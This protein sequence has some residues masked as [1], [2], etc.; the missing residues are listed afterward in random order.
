[1]TLRN[2]LVNLVQLMPE[3]LRYLLHES[4]TNRAL[5]KKPNGIDWAL[6]PRQTTFVDCLVRQTHPQ[7]QELT[8]GIKRTCVYGAGVGLVGD[9]DSTLAD[10]LALAW[11]MSGK[12]HTGQEVRVLGENYSLLEQKG[13]RT[14]KV[15]LKVVDL[16]GAFQGRVEQRPRRE[17]G[18]HRGNQSVHRTSTITDVNMN[19][20]VFI[21]RPFMFNIQSIIKIAVEQDNRSEIP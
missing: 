1:M 10:K 16:R 13:S 4:S 5:R 12:L 3:I 18:S 21:L 14:L 9:V 8:S 19:E 17:F 6:E 15:G 2:V 7:F 11:N 20:N